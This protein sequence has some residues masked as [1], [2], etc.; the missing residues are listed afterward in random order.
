MCI[1]CEKYFKD[2]NASIEALI[3]ASVIKT[4]LIKDRT[5]KW[6]R[7]YCTKCGETK[8]YYV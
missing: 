5:G 3:K 8:K 2:N 1:E 6:Y 4:D 7:A